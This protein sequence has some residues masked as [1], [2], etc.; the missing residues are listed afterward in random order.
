[1]KAILFAS[2]LALNADPQTAGKQTGEGQSGKPGSTEAD[3]TRNDRETSANAKIDGQWTVV[4]MEKDG[5]KGEKA[6]NDTVTIRNNVVTW[7]D[8]GKEHK[9]RLEFGP[10][11]TIISYPA[12][13][14]KSGSGR[15]RTSIDRGEDRSA[16]TDRTHPD[17]TKT[18][19][20]NTDRTTNDRTTGA[21]RGTGATADRGTKSDARSEEGTHRGVY[22]LS[23]EYLCISM[24][25]MA[26]TRG[27]GTR[28]ERGTGPGTESG[29]R[30][31]AGTGP[32]AETVTRPAPGAGLDKTVNGSTEKGTRPAAG[33]ARGAAPGAG[34]DRTVSGSADL[35]GGQPLSPSF[36]LILKKASSGSSSE[37]RK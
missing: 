18:D 25:D 28:T 11:Q 5:K 13:D 36:V 15:D 6:K 33:T 16:T 14:A 1:M 4:Y 27:S 17:R 30:P 22:I 24:N 12:D 29:T 31:A 2:L 19:R 9:M 35:T 37:S 10:M 34:L 21:D 3:R 20:I 7:T 32:G 26:S 23:S 8:A